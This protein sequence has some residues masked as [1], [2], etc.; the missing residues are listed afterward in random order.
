MEENPKIGIVLNKETC[1]LDYFIWGGYDAGGIIRCSF[2]CAPDEWKYVE[3]AK[4]L[5]D[6]TEQEITLA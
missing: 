1:E 3:L 2:D 4:V 6:I 5:V